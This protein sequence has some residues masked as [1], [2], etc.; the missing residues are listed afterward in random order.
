MTLHQIMGQREPVLKSRRI[1]IERAQ[2]Q[3]A[4]LYGLGPWYMHLMTQLKGSL[5]IDR[6]VL[7]ALQ[8][9]RAI[10]SSLFYGSCKQVSKLAPL[11][12]DNGTFSF[13]Y[14]QLCKAVSAL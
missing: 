13:M 10:Y 12:L 2:T 1:G 3:L 8:R 7:V 14:W 4:T 9:L 11:G 6:T 5:P